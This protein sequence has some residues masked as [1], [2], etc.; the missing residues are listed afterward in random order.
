MEF[1]KFSLQIGNAPFFF[2]SPNGDETFFGALSCINEDIF[3]LNSL[4]FKDDDVVIDLGCNVGIVSM[5]M[6]KLNPNI[7]I[8]SFDASEYAVKCFKM[9]LNDNKIVNTQVYNLAVGG[10]NEK[11]SF[12]SNSKETSC[13]QECAFDSTRTDLYTSIDKIGID[14]IFD[15]KILN[16]DKVKFL[17]VDIEGSEFEMLDFIF[18]KRPDILD[19]IEFINLEI[20]AHPQFKNRINEIKEKVS[21]KFGDRALFQVAQ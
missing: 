1:Q 18:E 21:N 4:K 14:E 11:I 17:K 6:A 8:Y 20:H 3:N 13:L 9:G 7:K 16:I 2:Y 12:S 19:R 10:K 15:S 5:V